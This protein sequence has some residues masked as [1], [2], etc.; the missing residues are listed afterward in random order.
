VPGTVL[1]NDTDAGR[2]DPTESGGRAGF[3]PPAGAEKFIFELADPAA[4]PPELVNLT[5]Q[6]IYEEGPLTLNFSGVS[7]D[8]V[9]TIQML[10]DSFLLDREE[11]IPPTH[12]MTFGA[13]ELDVDGNLEI[14]IA[15][16]MC[17]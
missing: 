15:S 7:E 3:S 2:I 14:Y 12:L 6:P 5:R 8:S 10:E 13:D 1:I 17:Q 4:D 11:L 16:G 9:I